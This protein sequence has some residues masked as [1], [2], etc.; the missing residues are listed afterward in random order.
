MSVA[1]ALPADAQEATPTTSEPVPTTTGQPTTTPPTETT[2]PTT[3]TT[4]APPTTETTTAP[5]TTTTQPAERPDLAVTVSFD[6]QAYVYGESVNIA[7]RIVN[8]SDVAATGVRVSERGNLNTT[9]QWGDLGEAPGATIAARATRDLALVGTFAWTSPGR[10][11]LPVGVHSAVEDLNPAD[12][13]ATATASVGPPKARFGGTVFEDRNGNGAVD[14]GEAVSGAQIALSGPRYVTVYSGFDGRF[15][16]A[17]LDEGTYYIDYSHHGY[18]L[19]GVGGA[20]SRDQLALAGDQYADVRIQAKPALRSLLSARLVFDGT[21]YDAGAPAAVRVVLT[22]SSQREV[23]GVTAICPGGSGQFEANLGALTPGGPGVLVPAGRTVFVTVTGTVP[24]SAAEVGYTSLSCSFAAPGFPA[25]SGPTESASVAVTGVP[26]TAT[27]ALLRE[28]NYEPVSNVP[29]SLLD[30]DSGQEVARAVSGADGT[31]TVTGVPTGRYDVRFDGPWTTYYQFTVRTDDTWPVTIFV[32]PDPVNNGRKAKVKAVATLDKQAYQSADPVKVTLT[33]T[34]VGNAPATDVRFSTGSGSNFS[35]DNGWGELNQGLT[36]EAGATR[37]FEY[38]G[39]VYSWPSLPDAVLLTGQFF[40]W[41]NPGFANGQFFAA[42]PWTAVFGDYRG[43]VYADKNANGRPDRGEAMAG[44][45]VSASGGRPMSG[46]EAVTDAAG[47]F[48]IPHLLQGDYRVY[49]MESEENWVIVGP[50]G[51]GTDAFTLTGAGRD[52]QIRAVP[53][54]HRSLKAQL[55]IEH[56]QYAKGDSA[57]AFVKLTNKGTVTLTGV[58]AQCGAHEGVL[59]TSEGWYPIGEP[60]PGTTLAVG[61]TKSFTVVNKVSD[62]DYRA[63]FHEVWCTFVADGHRAEGGPQTGDTALVLGALGTRSAELVHDANGDWVFTDDERL[64]GVT[65]QLIDD[66]TGRAVRQ[67][68]TDARGR[69]TFADQQAG[70]YRIHVVGP[71]AFQDNWV[72]TFPITEGTSEWA[73]TILMVPGPEQ[74]PIS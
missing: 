67:T 42:A 57:K 66:V 5:P 10:L 36:I 52:I 34:N 47:R 28:D 11:E 16:A 73:P 62:E 33:V 43:L 41:S 24:A 18:T 3:D 55:T 22:N 72:R 13:M 29:V 32:A 6:K 14:Q 17:D 25:S 20:E 54:L 35:P 68:V 40:S 26:A 2:P 27:G 59:D 44:V 30:P 65:V 9:G 50:A 37:T 7:V 63:G 31:F 49:F 71:W 61:E 8:N 21:R 1:V 64:S 58:K 39:T 60:D 38:T 69:F 51:D 53:A 74:P 12:N 46:G 19:F 56:D 45:R 48:S 23:A 70:R 4:T 15:D